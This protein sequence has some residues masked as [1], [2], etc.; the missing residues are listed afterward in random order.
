MQCRD[1][2]FATERDAEPLPRAVL[3]DMDGTLTEPMLDF[4]AIKRDMGIGDRPI[5]E[6]LPMLDP[7]HRVRAADALRRHEDHAAENSRLNPGCAE[8]LEWLA[9]RG[10]GIALVTRNTRR[11]TDTV[12]RLH[13][14]PF[15][16][17]VTRDDCVYK[18]NPAPLRLA[19]QRLSIAPTDAWMVGDGSHDVQAGL[20]AGMR[21]V[22]I[23]HG[24]QRDF[25][26]EPWRVARDL[27]ELRNMLQSC[28]CAQTGRTDR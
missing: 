26:E 24:R 18:P 12:M 10:V 2:S 21:T 22:W 8:L 11:S 6:T 9:S 23:S 28:R 25:P 15:D 4:D 20:A 7:E 3:F 5:L 1:S 17:L 16:I 13:A 19:C 14:L 27:I